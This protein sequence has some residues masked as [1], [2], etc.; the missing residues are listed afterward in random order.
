MQNPASEIQFRGKPLPS[1]NPRSA[2]DGCQQANQWDCTL[3]I[4]QN[5]TIIVPVTGLV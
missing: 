2:P 1:A 4:T 5:Q 3:N